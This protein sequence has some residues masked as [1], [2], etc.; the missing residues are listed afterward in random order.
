LLD[1]SDAK[2]DE[3]GRGHISTVAKRTTK[4][5]IIK[6]GTSYVVIQ[7]NN[8]GLMIFGKPTNI[9]KEEDTTVSKTDDLKYSM[10]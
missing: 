6:I 3:S 7:G 5:G 10:P 9:G 4:G 8:E 2:A 1:H